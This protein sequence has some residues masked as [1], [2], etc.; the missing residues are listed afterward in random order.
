MEGKGRNATVLKV[1]FDLQIKHHPVIWV[2]TL[3]LVTTGLKNPDMCAEEG[4]TLR[5]H[6]LKCRFQSVK[7]NMLPSSAL[8]LPA[9]NQSNLQGPLAAPTRCDP[10]S[11]SL[12]QLQPGTQLGWAAPSRALPC[13]TELMVGG[14]WVCQSPPDLP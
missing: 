14:S 2:P 12:L 8:S 11:H 6:G 7:Y 3:L 13:P 9:K 1:S 4:S 10:S 5:W